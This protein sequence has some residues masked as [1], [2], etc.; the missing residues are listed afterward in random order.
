MGFAA[1]EITP[2]G[3]WHMIEGKV[4]SSITIVMIHGVG[5]D[6]T[7]FDEQVQVLKVN[8]RVVRYDLLGH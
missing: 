5:L 8:Y 6:H 3:T 7:M 4:D 2:E 1:P